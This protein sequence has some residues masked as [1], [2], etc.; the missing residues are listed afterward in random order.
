MIVVDDDFGSI[1]P[2][3]V[4]GLGNILLG[5][6]GLGV[7]TVERLQQMYDLPPDVQVIDGGT[8]GLNLLPYLE[9][10]N[11]VVVEDAIHL[12]QPPGALIRLQ[13]DEIPIVL[14]QKM[15]VH[16]VGLQ[17]LLAV[18]SLQG[19]LPAGLVVWGMEPGELTPGLDFSPAVAAGLD[20]L[21]VAVV[22]EL[23]GCGLP[24]RRR[25]VDAGAPA[26]ASAIEIAPDRRAAGRPPAWTQD[27]SAQADLAAERPFAPNSFGGDLAAER[28]FAPNSF[29]GDLAAERPL[30]PNSFGGDLA[31]ERPLAPNS[32]GG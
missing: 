11:L 4:L 7:R 3:L 12:D 29:G 10:V 24:V 30:A 1:G 15:S 6:E 21:L 28:P 17:E 9:G 25:Q 20:D 14:G 13:G 23:R 22:R 32:F 16:Q 26:A 18:A 5:D 8:L 31:A 2:T 19:I 27:R